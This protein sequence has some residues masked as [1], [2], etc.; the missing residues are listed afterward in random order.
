MPLINIL[1]KNNYSYC[2]KPSNSRQN[3]SKDSR[4]K[5][6]KD[7]SSRG[8]SSRGKGSRG[9][10][11]RGKSSRSKGSRGKSSKS[12]SSITSKI[13]RKLRRRPIVL[14]SLECLDT[15]LLQKQLL[16]EPNLTNLSKLAKLDLNSK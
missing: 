11:S 10:S 7:K 12:N 14:S 2:N 8:K 16:L 1:D 3:N 6:S 13:N 4:G 5:G 15:L 9:K